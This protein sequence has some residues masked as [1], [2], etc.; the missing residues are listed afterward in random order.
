MREKIL[1]KL[2]GWQT[3]HPWR[4]LILVAAVT[5]IMAGFA[6]QLTVTMRTS[7]LLPEKD[8]R[9]V[10]FNKILEEFSTATSLVVVVQGKEQRIKEF[11]DTLAPEILELKDS[12][13]NEKYWNQIQKLQDKRKE[14]IEQG[15]GE[16]RLF[17]LQKE[18][19]E[20]EDRIDKPLFQRVDYKAEID[21]LRDHIL[22]LAK[23]ENLK[24]MKEFFMDPNLIGLIRNLNNAME[25]EYV[26]QQDSISTREK[27]DGAVNLLDGIQN[28]IEHLQIA[29]NKES[30]PVEEIKD[31]V[32]KLL[33]GEPYFIS[34]DREALILNALPTF[35]LMDR[36]LLMVAAEKVQVLV[37][38]LLKDYPEVE[39][40]LTGGIAREYTEQIY[41][42][43]SLGYTS[44]F[45][46]VGILLLLMISFR[47][48]V[49]PVFAVLN[50][51]VG[52][53]WAMGAAYILVGQLN[54]FTSMMSIVLLGLGID[55]SIHLISG[56]TEWRAAGDSISDSMQ[57]TFLKSGKGIVT[58][59]LTTS[60]AF[61]TLMI[62]QTRGMK[63][64]GI[65][66][67]GGLLAILLATMLFLPVLL[68]FRERRREKV[69]LKGDA[70][71]KEI[72]DL[73]FSF[74]GRIG[75]WLSRRYLFTIAASV[76]ITVLLVWGATHMTFDHNYMNL[77]PKGLTAF[78][79]LDTVKEKFDLS[80]EYALVLAD[81]V[82]TSRD[83]G[84]QYRELGTVAMTDDISVYLPSPEQQAK[85]IPHIDEIK[86]TMEES[87]IREEVRLEEIPTLIEEIQRLEMNVMEIQDMAFL[88]GQDK[89]DNKCKKIVGDPE[90]PNSPNII[91][92]LY[93]EIER[94]AEDT[95]AGFS[96][97]QRIFAPNFKQSV[98][99]MASTES[100][101]MDDLPV[102]I[103]DRYSNQ[104]RDLFLIS[105]YP[106]FNPYEDADFL[107][108]FVADLNTVTERATGSP[109]LSLALI[110]IFGRDGRN[111]VL[112]TLVIVFLL[113]CV[114]FFNPRDALMAM[115]PLALGL[116][117]MVGLMYVVGMKLSVMS[118]MGLPLIIGIGI[119]DGV[120]IIHRWKHEGNNRVYTV[121]SS[122]GKAILLTSLTTMLAFGSLM[123]SIFPGWVQFGAS[124]FIG[125]AAC[126]LTTV[127]VLSGLFGWI[128]RKK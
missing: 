101:R 81:D 53:I 16:G 126:F 6:G 46:L 63:E 9:V 100:I 35:T 32:D 31:T 110:D 41:S 26:G 77:E 29:A 78:T 18:V 52:L 105:V 8:P 89:V 76:G 20:I 48:W 85:R 102:T 86:K 44:L 33:F 55:F 7:D 56:F 27:E 122:T 66:T 123:F 11:A 88:G 59:A 107:K 67:G 21:F 47:M 74:L 109:P 57:K 118:V 108:R 90:V 28:L 12:G 65:V 37:D 3:A 22:M 125:V 62:S 19:Q 10:N 104:E 71:K 114:D 38:E 94:E 13:S 87:I 64:M 60:C 34:Y 116:L 72:R 39:A 84:E 49:A 2:A 70:E 50:L 54:M 5:I 15:A 80:M 82:E 25:K 43:K 121:F 93:E 14:L 124:L 75:E 111:A 95:A 115:V 113:L 106:N 51:V 68:V 36:D 99:R 23:E 61:L 83:Y 45:A 58:G 40:G 98:L 1:K 117:W 112:L 119:D 91:R 79:L 120:H 103:L 69:H 24:N 73:S 30:L 4:M 127:L 42:Q 128:E 17:D 97:F 96:D 92:G